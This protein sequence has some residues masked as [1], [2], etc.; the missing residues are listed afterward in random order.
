MPFS[1]DQAEDVKKQLIAEI[2]KL[3][4]ENKEQIKEYI[5]GLD[6]QGLEDFL[7][8]NKIKYTDT[9]LAQEPGE[10]EEQKESAEPKCVFCSIIKGELHSYKIL[11]ND[12]AIAI[13]EINPLSRGHAIVLPVEHTSIEKMPKSAMSLA[14]KIAKKIKKKLKPEDI[15][16]ETSNFQGHSLVNIVPI[17]KNEPLKKRK[18]DEKELEQLQSKLETKKRASRKGKTKSE[19]KEKYDDSKLIKIGFRIP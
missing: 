11:E 1:P 4:N 18:A 3:P 12:K 14:Q 8:K 15:K 7:K 17:Y 10:G 16:I 13:L 9:G 5:K 2:D 19:T 6:E